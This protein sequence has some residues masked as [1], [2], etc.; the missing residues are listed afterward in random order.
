MP[1]RKFPL[2]GDSLLDLT[3]TMSFR[4][5]EN[6]DELKDDKEFADKMQ[7]YIGHYSLDEDEFEFKNYILAGKNKIIINFMVRPNQTPSQVLFDFR[8][9]MSGWL[10]KDKDFSDKYFKRGIL[11]SDKYKVEV[12]R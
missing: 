10:R 12:N 1:K 8:K 2:Y 4:W 3:A 9:T 5:L 6:L 7:T 11:F